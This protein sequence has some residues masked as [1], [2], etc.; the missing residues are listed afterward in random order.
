MAMNMM[1]NNSYDARVASLLNSTVQIAPSQWQCQ[2]LF[3]SIEC[4]ESTFTEAH[5]A[6]NM[7]CKVRSLKS[8]IKTPSLLEDIRI[9]RNKE[10]TDFEFDM[11]VGN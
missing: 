1:T 4:F 3:E 6:A 11:M 2:E 9:S 8:Q 7:S 5:Q 10:F